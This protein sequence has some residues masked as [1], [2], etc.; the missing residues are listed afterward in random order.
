VPDDAA[1][2]ISFSLH[3]WHQEAWKNRH[4]IIS[5]LTRWHRILYVEEPFDLRDVLGDRGGRGRGGRGGVEALGEGLTRYRPPKYLPRNY[6]FPRLERAC[7]RLRIAHLRAVC[8][9]LKIRRPVL[10]VWDPEFRYVLGHLDESLRAY[11]VDDQYSLFS[12]GDGTALA[13]EERA[14]LRGVDLVFCTSEAL[15]EDKGRVNPNV[16]LVANGVDYTAFAAAATGREPVPSALRAIRRPILGFVGNLDDKVDYG[17]LTG[18]ARD[19]PGWSVVLIG[20]DNIFTSG[21]RAEFETLRACANVT[22]L[23]SRPLAE[24]PAHIQGMDVCAIPNRIN[25]FTR[26]VYPIKLHEYLAVGKPVISTPIPSVEPFAPTVHL[27]ASVAEWTRCLREAVAETGD[28][29]VERRQAT[30]RLHTWEQ[31]AERVHALLAAVPKNPG[32]DSS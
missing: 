26:F 6:R 22:W 12:G 4:Q 31:R 20:P 23:G 15:C 2:I 17:L 10:L 28:G 3:R 30:A 16:H 11:F 24:I 1:D 9:S 27:A 7:R 8:R 21:Y 14:L 19:N 5:R 18:V 25:E 13:A 29:W 32:R